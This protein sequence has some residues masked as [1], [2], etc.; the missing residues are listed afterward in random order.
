MLSWCCGEIKIRHELFLHRD[1][2]TDSPSVTSYY[3]TCKRNSDD[4]Q[5]D[6][7]VCMLGRCCLLEFPDLASLFSFFLFLF[8]LHFIVFFQQFAELFCCCS[9]SLIWQLLN[10]SSSQCH[11]P[12][13]LCRLSCFY[14]GRFSKICCRLWTRHFRLCVMGDSC[15]YFFLTFLWVN[16]KQKEC[17]VKYGTVHFFL[18]FPPSRVEFMQRVT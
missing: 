9:S 12:V 8:F 10:P 1:H 5:C 13:S 4:F 15:C 18:S 3:V 2:N 17:S 7:T 14:T 6:V 16:S 11:S